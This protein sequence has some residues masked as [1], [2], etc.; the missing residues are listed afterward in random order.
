MVGT[1]A[2]TRTN[3]AVELAAADAQAPRYMSW[4]RI[5][6]SAQVS[7]NSWHPAGA[8]LSVGIDTPAPVLRTV[9]QSPPHRNSDHRR[10]HREH[11]LCSQR[12][13]LQGRAVRACACACCVIACARA[14]GGAHVRVHAEAD[15]RGVADQRTGKAGLT[16]V[17]QDGHT[18]DEIE[19]KY[20]LCA[21]HAHT[22]GPEPTCTCARTFAGGPHVMCSAHGHACTCLPSHAHVHVRAAG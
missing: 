5:F 16:G 4:G 9:P 8:C 6:N 11:N 20:Y 13:S 10:H 2:G 1:P 7:E 19:A 15:G 22:H 14:F 3:P 17:Y 12:L 18:A 21:M